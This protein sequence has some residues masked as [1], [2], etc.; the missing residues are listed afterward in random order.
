MVEGPQ[1]IASGKLSALVAGAV[2]ALVVCSGSAMLGAFGRAAP[3]A[4]GSASGAASGIDDEET[5]APTAGG[6]MP[7]VRLRMF[8]GNRDPEVH[9]EWRR[10]VELGRLIYNLPPSQLGP[11]VY[12]SLEAGEGK[13]R[14]LLS[15][16]AVPDLCTEVGLDKVLETLDAEYAPV[17]YEKADAAF[18]RYN[19]CRRRAGEEMLDYIARLRSAKRQL[20]AEDPGTMFSATNFAQR[21]LRSSGLTKIEQRQ[22]LASAGAVLGC[23]TNCVDPT[24][25][26]RRLSS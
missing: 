14:G 21:M 19:S 3:A 5:A 10:E 24:I 12:L 13:P 25:N 23:R 4:A 22:V 17:A 18:K 9:R 11:L 2:F 16:V 26:V 6:R 20:E 1:R 15:H 7:T 8:D